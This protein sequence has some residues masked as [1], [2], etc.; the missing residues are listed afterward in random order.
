MTHENPSAKS[1]QPK[2]QDIPL[3]L[4]QLSAEM[5]DLGIDMEY[6][7]G[8]GEIAAHGIEL[9]GSAC[10]ARSWAD[11]IEGESHAG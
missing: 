3:R 7:G 1:D 6:L 5:L 10:I 4:R 11:G 8:W 2:I 9:Q